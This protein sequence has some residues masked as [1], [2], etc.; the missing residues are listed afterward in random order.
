MKTIRHILLTQ[1]K[2]IQSVIILTTFSILL[3]LLRI[4]LTNTYYFIFLI[5][6][7][8]LAGIPYLISSYL[9]TYN[10]INKVSLLTISFVWLLFL[11]NA[12]Y[13]VTDLFHLKYSHQDLL[14]ID[15]LI[16]IVF[17]ITGLILFYKS[18]KTMCLIFETYV[19]KRVV[20]FSLPILFMLVGFGVYLGRFLRF[21]SWEIIN[22]PW[23]IIETI[24]SIILHP[25]TYNYAWIFSIVFGATLYVGYYI[26]DSTANKTKK[27][28]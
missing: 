4:K 9:S 21:N 28:S 2:T 5:W 17:A 7:L 15:T 25:I 14:W 3:L 6:N 13:I 26:S 27:A 20:T 16:I 18:I 8:F 11:P 22:K 12:P 23:T 19:E 24:M 10:T 1:Y